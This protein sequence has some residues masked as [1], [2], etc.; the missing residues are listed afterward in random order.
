MN[1]P[2]L[3]GWCPRTWTGLKIAHCGGRGGCHQTFT[4]V[5]H[6]DKHR[7]TGKCVEPSK[8]GLEPNQ[9]GNWREPGEH[10][11]FEETGE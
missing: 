6:F 1:Q 2:H 8:V 9:Y 5:T 7:K 3:C 10:Y 4:V 11:N